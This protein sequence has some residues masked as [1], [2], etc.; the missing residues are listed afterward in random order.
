M[1]KRVLVVHGH[2]RALR[3]QVELLLL[4]L[5]LDPI[6]LEDQPSGSQTIIEKV[7]AYGRVDYAV[8]LLTPDDV[9]RSAASP[10]NLRPRARQNVVLELGYF[11]GALGRSRV[12]VLR[13]SPD[14]EAPGDVDGVVYTS[15][16]EAGRWR[17]KLAKNISAAGLPADLSGL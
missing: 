3:D 8:V 13:A 12:A 10:S 5:K 11:I 1:G 15:V 9:G 4:R 2:D 16:D 6:V 7:E 17:Q 14:V